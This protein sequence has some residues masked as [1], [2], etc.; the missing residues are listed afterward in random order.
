MPTAL[1]LSGAV[2]KGA[3]EAGVLQVL[4]RHR[5]PIVSIVGASAGA[6]NGALFAAGIH[7][8]RTVDA[9]DLLARMWDERGTWG[10]AVDLSARDIARGR[11]AS[12]SDK[13]RRLLRTSI[14]TFAP[15]TR[16]IDLRIVVTAAAGDP[17]VRQR[18]GRTSYESFLAFTGA[19]FDRP[20]TRERLYQAVLA[21]AAFPGLY[22]PVDIPQLGECLDGGAVNNTPIGHALGGHPEIR[23]VVVVTHTPAL[24]DT[25][26]LRGFDLVGHIGDILVTERLYRDLRQARRL[27]HQ[28]AALARLRTQGTLSRA[29]ADAVKR[30]L[31][32]SNK[33]PI[34][35]LEI[36][37]RVALRGGA[38]SGLSNRA[39]RREYLD[40]G[41]RAA[42]ETL[43]RVS[44]FAKAS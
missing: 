8:G 38:F 31:A 41:R 18:E 3:F 19:D 34:E 24:V 30:A 2:A 32:L 12:T 20:E 29:S 4:A 13:L 25:P 27:N 36:R 21:S 23:R 37:P 7:A 40:A 15:G 28:L 26:R 11:G 42:K 1:V 10:H 9:A 33:R 16:P 6:L 39:L 5:L 43:A 14:E 17:I 35:I 44:V 22:A